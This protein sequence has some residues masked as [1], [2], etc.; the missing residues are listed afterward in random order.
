MSHLVITIGCEYG[1]K[2]NQIG[3]KI[4][5]D[6]GFQFYDRNIVDAI[7]HEVGI[8]GEI[9]EKVEEGVTI[10]GKGAEGE[11]QESFHNTQILQ[12]VR[13]MYRKRLSASCRTENPV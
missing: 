4:A 6:L 10:V 9:M 11:E 7:I 2:G 1:A 8:P 5:E 12:N 13:F 3:R